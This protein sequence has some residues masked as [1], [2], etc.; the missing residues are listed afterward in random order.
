[1]RRANPETNRYCLGV[2]VV[3]LD[4]GRRLIRLDSGGDYMLDDAPNGDKPAV[5]IGLQDVAILRWSPDGRWVGF[6]RRDNGSTQLWR[7][8][9]DG[10]GSQMLTHGQADVRDFA[11][12]ADGTSLIIEIHPGVARSNAAIDREGLVGWHLDDRAEIGIGARPLVVDTTPPTIE[13]LDP[14]TGIGRPGGQAERTWL[15]QQTAP[16]FG[17]AGAGTSGRKSRRA[18]AE[19]DSLHPADGR[20]WTSQDDRPPTSCEASVCRGQILGVW[21]RPKDRALTYMRREGWSRGSIGV[22]R[23]QP[24]HIP[25]R[26]LDTDDLLTGCTLAADQLVCMEETSAR[27]RH[28]VMLNPNH[29]TRDLLFDPNPEWGHVALGRIERLH[30]YNKFGIECFG[31]LV[32]PPGLT[33]RQRLPLVVVQYITRGFLRG[34]TGD[35]VPIQL[36][37]AQGF[38]VLSVQNPLRIGYDLASLFS[39]ALAGQLVAAIER[40]KARHGDQAPVALG[41]AGTLPDVAEQHL[42][43]IVG[44]RGGD[45]AIELLRR[46]PPIGHHTVSRSAE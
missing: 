46:A 44:E 7:A 34:G 38:A 6:L 39:A 22:Y 3:R 10:S 12:S 8:R 17:G 43:A 35:E 27:P 15:Q 20:L 29:G 2:Y 45:V 23:W 16:D 25:H 19:V 37:A 40:D 31:D 13:S 18:W 24:G 36:L 1:M 42:V 4:A 30:W 9:S 14:A 5:P 28:L 11:W 33:G 41:Q 26:V 32:L 21:W